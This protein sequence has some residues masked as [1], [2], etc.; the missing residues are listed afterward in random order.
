MARHVDI[1]RPVRHI[2]APIRSSVP[3]VRLLKTLAIST[4]TICGIDELPAQRA[5]SVTHVLSVLDPDWP[6]LDAF[7][8]YGPHHRTTLRF[9]DII[10]PEEGRIL[11]AP[12][13]VG[14]IL[15]FGA[16]LMATSKDRAEGHLL[17]HCHMGV[18]RSTAAMV[19][20]LAQVTP[21]EDEDGLFARLREIRPQAWPNS[22]MIGYADD[23]LG[24]QGR[25]VAALGR[26]YGHQVRRDPKFLEWMR[27]LGRDRELGMAV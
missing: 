24:R 15:R 2:V 22:L 27:Q 21:G 26:H 3:K 19:S 17:V 6:E 20:L 14:A 11:P 13:H 9:H 5:N 7:Q 1:V 25:L 8:T 23:L 18:S 4:L 12:E 10:N 16:D